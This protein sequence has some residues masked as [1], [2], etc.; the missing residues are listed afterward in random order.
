MLTPYWDLVVNGSARLSERHRS[1]IDRLE[2]LASVDGADELQVDATAWD[3]V[4]QVYRFLGETILAPGN[5]VIVYVGYED[6]SPVPLQ[7][8]QLISE[9]ATY[10]DE[11]VKVKIRG[12]SAALYLVDYTTARKFEIGLP[13]SEIVRQIAEDHGLLIWGSSLEDT[14]ARS[15]DK[16]RVKPQGTSDWKF[17]QD[18]A[19]VNGFG[20]PYVRYD[21]ASDQD[22]LYFRTSRLTDQGSRATFRYNPASEGNTGPATCFRFNPVLRIA[23]IPTAVQVIGWDPDK[24]EPI[25]VVAEITAQGQKTTVQRGKEVGKYP[26]AIKSGAQLQVAILDSSKAADKTAKIEAFSKFTL[27][28][29]DSCFEFAARWLDTRSRAFLTADST[30]VG[31]EGLWIAQT[32]EWAGLAET[33]AGLWEVNE[34]RHKIVPGPYVCEVQLGRVLQEAATPTEGT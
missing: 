4:D 2:V 27:H 5:Y 12:L 34:C 28:T 8:F 30:V 18:L 16:G 22:V 13:D 23:G 1:L 7:R 15:P 19:K 3:S 29:T 14:P 32:H 25:A 6:T 33:H 26:P 9:E 11:G 17:L 31:W 24:Q 10:E 20:P 21:A